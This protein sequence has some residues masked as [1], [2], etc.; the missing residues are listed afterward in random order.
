[1]F[2]QGNIFPYFIS[3]ASITAFLICATGKPVS[4]DVEYQIPVEEPVPVVTDPR[5]EEA[6]YRIDYS[7]FDL[8]N[9]SFVDLAT[10]GINERTVT[11]I[12][13]IPFR[14]D[15]DRNQTE[16]AVVVMTRQ[17]GERVQYYLSASLRRGDQ[18]DGADSFL[19]GDRITLGHATF[20]NGYILQEFLDRKPGEPYTARPTVLKTA[21]VS[22]KNGG[23][24]ESRIFNG[25]I[26]ND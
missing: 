17:T 5:P 6:T 24:A 9:G 21:R 11:S 2:E 19:L 13:S 22:I 10:P 3:I 1:M 8:T 7:V 4:T 26:R 14:A 15:V 16:D 18:Y 25:Y 12:V 23:I 20:E